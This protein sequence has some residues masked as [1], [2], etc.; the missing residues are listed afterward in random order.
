MK[1][2][3]YAGRIKAIR[4]PTKRCR[5]PEAR[6]N[7]CEACGFEAS[8]HLVAGWNMAKDGA[9]HVPADCWR[10]KPRVER[11]VA[12]EEPSV[13]PEKIPCQAGPV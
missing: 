2:W 5:I 8:H 6:L 3:V 13:E 12:A 11:S 4:M 7:V 10:M 1:R 9:R